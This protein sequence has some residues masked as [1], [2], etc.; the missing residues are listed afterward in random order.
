MRLD[1]VWLAAIAV[2]LA[3]C[4]SGSS[5][6]GNKP[7]VC[8][9]GVLDPGDVCDDGD[10]NSD[11]APD[12]CRTDCMPAGC[13][14]GVVDS[15]EECDDGTRNGNGPAACRNDCTRPGP[16]GNG[17]LDP[18]EECDPRLA[19]N[20]CEADCTW[21]VPA[22][23]GAWATPV[24]DARRGT[25]TGPYG[26]RVELDDRYASADLTTRCNENNG[27]DQVVAFAVSTPGDL[28]VSLELPAAGDGDIAI[29]VRDACDDPLAERACGPRLGLN[30]PSGTLIVRDIATGLYFVIVDVFTAEPIGP[31][32]ARIELRPPLGAGD[33]CRPDGTWGR[34]DPA[35]GTLACVDPDL[36]GAGSC[37]P[38]STGACGDAAGP[39][40]EGRAC[41]PETARAGTCTATCGDGRLDSGE[42]CDD[43]NAVDGDGCSAGCGAEGTSCPDA[44]DLSARWDGATRHAV[45]KGRGMDFLPPPGAPGHRALARFRAPAA[46]VYDFTLEKGVAI[47]VRSSCET[48]TWLDRD[49]EPWM[50]T[51]RVALAAGEEVFVDARPFWDDFFLHVSSTTCGDGVQVLPETCDDGNT[52]P[53]DGC[54]PTCVG[55]GSS[56]TDPAPIVW[57]PAT[58]RAVW[59]GAA[60]GDGA[61]LEYSCRGTPVRSRVGRFVAPAPG[62]YRFTVGTH[63]AERVWLAVR[64]TCD[65]AGTDRT[66]DMGLS[67]SRAGTRRG[68]STWPPARRCSRS[69]RR[70]AIPPSG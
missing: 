13:G 15:G 30:D 36:D 32:A 35:G 69:S 33:A 14:D 29:S 2:G 50:P 53:G 17:T 44:V 47:Y 4:S 43:G 61:Q 21:S 11:T 12:A 40:A 38:A 67:S 5:A 56:C 22:T 3:A 23:C 28:I 51:T 45:W 9:D 48:T 63:W 10:R 34:C 55:G 20:G 39:C 49:E 46:G 60:P 18:G 31:F 58:R 24:M 42:A 41:R 64:S 68:R 59:E 52:S 54:S 57:D 62:R 19:A 26:Y 66:C 65:A 37:V 1:L 7:P 70:K 25:A 6:G 16:C 27:V 8:G